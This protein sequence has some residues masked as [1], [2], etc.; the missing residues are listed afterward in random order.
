LARSYGVHPVEL[1]EIQAG[2]ATVNFRVVDDTGR[3][4]FAKVYRGGLERERAAIELA[5]FAKHGGL[6]VPGVRR[7]LDGRTI[8]DRAP[9]SLWEFV[10]GE[11]AEGGISGARWSAV[12]AVLGGCIDGCPNT[13]RPRRRCV[14]RS[15]YGM[16]GVRRSPSIGL[17]RRMGIARR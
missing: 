3:R 15:E 9:M 12:G 11:T 10:D 6:P 7:T 5:E 13:L 2:T 1:T 17:S 14:R 4:W 16:S 8:D